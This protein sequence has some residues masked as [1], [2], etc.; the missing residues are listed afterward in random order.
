MTAAA[1]FATLEPVLRARIQHDLDYL[2]LV[3]H[4]VVAAAGW[5]LVEG[6]TTQPAN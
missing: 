6:G 2:T 4:C 5:H 3:A 1:L